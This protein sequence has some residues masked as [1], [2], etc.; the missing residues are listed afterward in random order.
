MNVR[1]HSSTWLRLTL[2]IL[3][4]ALPHF[5]HP[6]PQL[7]ESELAWK[8]VTVEGRKTAVFTMFVDS[9]GLMWLGTNNGLCFY[10]GVM[11]HPVGEEAL[12]G[13]QIYSI[14]EK[15]DR[16]Y[17][18]S[19]NGLMVYEYGSGRVSD[20]HGA[21]PKEIR[22][23]LLTDDNLLIGGLNG[24]FSL[25]LKSD[26]ISDISRGLP[27]RSV[28]SLMRDSRGI[29]YAG[30]YGGL[31]RWDSRDG[32][33]KS[34]KVRI[35]QKDVGPFFANCILESDDRE[36]IYVGAEGSLFSYLPSSDRWEKVAQVESNNIKSLCNGEEGHLLIGT[37]NGVFDLSAVGFRHFRHD[38]RQELSLADNEIWCIMADTNHNIWTG[39][40]R[41]F[42]IASNSNSI[43]T[44]KLGTL[45]HSG[46]GNEIHSIHRDCR[47]TLWLAGTNGVIR[48]SE[49]GRPDWYRHSES[50]KSLSHNRV[51]AMHEDSGGVMW[52]A[53]DAG[54]NRYNPER[55]G[56]DN[57]R[58]VDTKRE[59]NSNWVYALIEDGDNF[60]VG[61]F[62]NG[63]HRVGKSK[64]ADGG[65]TVVSDFSLNAETPL[66]DGNALTNNLVNDVID[67]HNGN[68]WILLFRDNVLS[69]FNKSTQEL[70]KFN[71]REL[72]GGYPT[73]ISLD[74]DGRV[75][76]AFKG[77][78]AVFGRDDKSEVVRFPLTDSDETI[79]AMGPVGNDMWIST[80]SNVW[81]VDGATLAPALLPIP[82][83]Y[84]TAIFEDSGSGKVFLGGIDELLEVEYSAI[85]NALDFKSVKMIL[86][87]GDDHSFNLSDLRESVAGLSIP[88]GGS[89]TLV[90]S[91][92]DYSPESLQRYMYKIAESPADTTG[93]WIVM[94]EG[95]NVISLS[96]LTMGDYDLLVKTVGSPAPAVA[97]PLRV[98][99][100]MALSWWA[101]ALYVLLVAAIAYWI[102]WYARRRNLSA[103]RE[104]ERQSALENVE[105]KLSFLSAISHDLKTP[106]SMIL[107][108]VSLMKERAKDPENRRNLETIY[109]NAVRLNNMI[110][111]TL[112]LQHLEDTD[113]N[114]LILSTFDVVE[115][116][117]SVFEVFQENNP[118]KK[119]VFHS[120]YSQLLIEA[121]AVKFE[122]VITNLLSNACKYSDEGATISCGINASGKTVEIVVADDGIGIA[123][124]DQP[125]VFQRMFRAPSTS[126]MKEGTGLGL[127][128]IK[129]YLEL[130]GGNIEL[131]SRE[132]QGTAFVV[133]LPLSEK[134]LTSQPLNPEPS[135]TT[136]SR[137]LIVEDN[138]QIA[139]F[140]HDLLKDDYQV[141]TAENGRSGLAIAASFA[142]DLII[143]DEMMPIMSGLEM[144]RRMKQHPRL[145]SIPMI[146]LTAKSDNRTE[147]ESIKLGI[148]VF[149]TKPF[150]P[151][152][153]I[154]RIRQ[155]LRTRS[156]IKET[157]RIQTITESETKPI[158]AESV[159]E[160]LLARIAKI[161]EDNISDPDLNVGLLCEKSGVPNKQLYRLIKKYMGTGPLD[162]IRSV[163]LQ[164]AAVLLSQH[165]FTVAE[166]SYMV[167]F[168]TP[169]Y[170][171]KCFQNHFGV[172][173]SQYQ[174]DDEAGFMG[175]KADKQGP[176]T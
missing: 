70:T 31:A 121:D 69:R 65:A 43:R 12:F 114:L 150:E 68:L 147:N 78:V 34:I 16:L 75:W 33:F 71:I 136:R 144:V 101:I 129:K 172:K 163:R 18:G 125:L 160:K 104:Q 83:K 13:S 17:L 111:R 45:T 102:I 54:I 169:S 27:H 51:R 67:D 52:F 96:D 98:S 82:Q 113:E 115:F 174:S 158:E 168:K 142:P 128:L 19:N 155:L 135:D 119:F 99:P 42:S 14:V 92:L 132:G 23:L 86:N 30:T 10:D 157:V 146:M 139:S 5:L 162:Y 143:A 107:G 24:I 62:L 109:D 64:F 118:Q 40:E 126:R 170:F 167:G 53:T 89:L 110:H 130:M 9:R 61:S 7:P 175:N 117:R 32:C 74:R 22:T 36:H 81:R 37:D 58:V 94:P 20:S 90:V 41:G 97:V 87:S 44:I 11:T 112:E 154:G 59:H 124:I 123:D 93:G 173:P 49:K 122:S 38:S 35:G 159:N 176:A 152:A 120:S 153:L 161:I 91:T 133:T 145:S 39:H 46:E 72:T 57:F 151:A 8:N 141:L 1:S 165:R 108:P 77:G 171:A 4:A 80:L 25:N 88:Y 3:V 131:Y 149:M 103:F 164:K 28:Y 138:L 134:E 116:C 56:F 105:R 66:A 76:C 6:A 29:L 50:E 63:L 15:D 2:L 127:Y 140:I 100:P 85:A 95:S 21:T 156:E 148:D 26:Q 166:I 84:Y 106:L 55:N 47:G 137:I 79:L 73:H 48:L 60:W